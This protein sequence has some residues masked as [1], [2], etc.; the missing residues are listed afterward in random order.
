MLDQIDDSMVRDTTHAH[1]GLV[2]ADA[3][4]PERSIEHMQLAGAPE[5]A[6]FGEPGRQCM[7]IEAMVRAALPLGR[8]EEA[9]EW[10]E[11]GERLASGLGLPIAEA[12]IKRG[13]ALVLLAQ[14][15]GGAAAALARLAAAAADDAGAPIEAARSRI[16]AGRAL[17]AAGRRDEAIE[18]L[19]AAR[20]ALASCGA[21]RL[22]QEAA[23]ELR[24]LGASVPAAVPRRSGD[25]G[26]IELSAREREVAEL[27]ATGASN[28]EIARVLFL[29]PKTVEGHMSRIFT[30]L[31][32]SSRARVAAIVAGR[33]R[34]RR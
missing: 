14:G 25:A 23:R 34:E 31:G 18:E 16:V 15:D 12:A 17:A 3:G 22:V 1:M 9:G 28:R 26:T 11:R 30:K 32:V 33:E 2:C 21:R 13:R 8:V 4:E 7:F 24:A 19:T 20:S 5:F 27:V 10:V 29:S 6:R